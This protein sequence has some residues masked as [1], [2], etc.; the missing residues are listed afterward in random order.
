MSHVFKLPR[1]ESC[2]EVVAPLTLSLHLNE[3]CLQVVAPAIHT[4]KR[5]ECVFVRKRDCT[6]RLAEVAAPAEFFQAPPERKFNVYEY[7]YI[8]MCA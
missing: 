1:L 3:S 7:I 8:C 2:L 6:C 4:G 5:D